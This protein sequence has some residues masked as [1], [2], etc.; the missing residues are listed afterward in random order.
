MSVHPLPTPHAPRPTF[1]RLTATGTY[2]AETSTDRSSTI[3]RHRPAAIVVARRVVGRQDGRIG[4]PGRV[5]WRTLDGAAHRADR[6]QLRY[7]RAGAG[8]LRRGHLPDADRHWRRAASRRA[9]SCG[10]P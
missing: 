8:L 10:T 7:Q 4:Q 9:D 6:V 1:L 5:L 3:E 2:G